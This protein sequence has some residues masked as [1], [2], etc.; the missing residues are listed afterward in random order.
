[1]GASGLKSN[2]DT[3]DGIWPAG[4]QPSLDFLAT[5]EFVQ[6]SRD[7]LFIT[8]RAGTGKSTLLRAIVRAL[9][10]Q[11]VIGA[12]TGIAAHHVGGDTLHYLFRLPRDL[13]LDGEEERATPSREFEVEDVTLVIDEISMVR[14]DAFNA[15]DLALRKMREADLPFG[16]VRVIAFGDT[17]QLAPVTSGYE[18]GRLKEAFGGEFFFYAPA[19]R[20]MRMVELT[21]VFR[22]EDPLFVDLLDQ[23]REGRVTDA[24]LA[25]LNGRVDRNYQ[26]RENEIWLCAT[27]PE[28]A[29]INHRR[30]D[31]LPGATRTYR[32]T[33]S[34]EARIKDL[35][36]EPEL[37]L[38]EG[39]RVIFIRNDRQRRWV[40]GTI[41]IVTRLDDNEIEVKVDGGET[42]TVG[43]ETWPKYKRTLV[44]KQVR[45]Q[46]VGSMS[47]LPI[48]LGWAITIHKSQGLTLD[49]VVFNAR[50][51]F[52]PGQAY[53]G[54][55]RVRTLEQLRLNRPL[56]RED[57]LLSPEA[58]GYRDLLTPLRFQ[59]GRINSSDST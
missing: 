45:N 37:P 40:N 43:V 16:G 29:A 33:F 8:G 32:A 58:V 5:L 55:S 30:L 44:D 11:L 39:A 23:I 18:R 57:V 2:L 1:M 21:E 20:S 19:A 42:F 3:G 59:K 24:A 34:G 48:R 26:T 35:P 50:S 56:R 51:L 17:H 7:N 9:D 36:T 46:E 49:R 10:T 6:T 41:G 52:A 15:I 27:N 13:L 28:A 54:L 4:V 25:Y 14:S 31:D 22:Q 53:V 47:Q 12:S 38:K